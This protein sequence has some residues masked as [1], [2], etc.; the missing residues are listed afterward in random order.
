MSVPHFDV[1]VSGVTGSVE[2]WQNAMNA[3]KAELPKLNNEQ[4]EIARKMGISEEEY[5][6][7]VL[8]GQY[9]ESR[10]KQRGETL[11]LRIAEV[12]D[13]LGKPYQL[14]TLIREG[15]NRRWVARINTPHEPK[16]VAIEIDLAND[17]I[18]SGTV[19]DMER[20]R[21]LM[22]RT[23]GRQDLIGNVQ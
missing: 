17:L 19:Q 4:K 23:L 22:L 13:G 15:V 7:G 1:F 9:G 3:P 12:L 11:G 8:V 20:L 10:Q 18:D 2:D 21:V 6:R 14:E 5:A 16:N